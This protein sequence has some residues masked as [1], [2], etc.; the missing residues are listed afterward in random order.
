VA[1]AAK[2]VS[3]IFQGVDQSGA[4]LASVE[5]GMARVSA[6]TSKMGTTAGEATQIWQDAAGK[7]RNA[8]G[9]FASEAELAAAGV[10]KV[11]KAGDKLGILTDAMK[12]LATAAVAKAFIDANVALEKFNAVMVA[13][14]GSTEEAKR[15]F[16]FVR[17]LSDR[18]GVSTLDVADAFSKFAAAT[19]GT[20]LEGEDARTIFE[21]F[22][23]AIAKLGG[24]SNDVAG[25]MVQLAQGVSKGKFELDDLKSIA[26]RVP[27]FFTTFAQALGVSTEELFEMVSAGKITGDEILKLG[28]VFSEQFGGQRVGGY[29]AELERL[30]NAIGDVFLLVGETGA[31][32]IFGDAVRV[33]GQ[34]VVVLTAI[35]EAL[36]KSIGTFFAALST[37]DWSN[38]SSTI[39]GIW[40]SASEKIG[41]AW[42]QMQK[43]GEETGK[44]K[45]TSEGVGSALTTGLGGA[46][47]AAKELAEQTKTLDKDLKEL[48]LDPKKLREGTEQ[49]AGDIVKAFQ[50]IAKNPA[51]NGEEIVAAFLVSL[52]KLTDSDKLQ[53]TR[54][55]IQQAFES[56]KISSEQ[57]TAAIGAL[58]DKASG[59][60]DGMINGAQKTT[61]IADE[62]KKAAD[63][64]RRAE[65]A[66]RAYQ[67]RLQELASNERIKLIEAR[68]AINVAEV[69][70]ETK[71]IE[72]AFES[73]NTTVTSTGDV[74]GKAFGALG[75][76]ESRF[77]PRFELIERQLEKENKRRDD[78]LEL[79][80]KLTEEQIDALKAKTKALQ[81]GDALIKVDGAG[82][83]PH[84]EAFMWEIL[85]TIQTR[86]NQDGLEM[87]VGV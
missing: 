19:K 33:T 51:A 69:E 32:E 65:E 76:I 24:S 84:L 62:T 22:S 71:R 36:G 39:D 49:A 12:S 63:E 4:A 52:G 34:A 18:L 23:S 48:G 59:L 40:S 55:A 87:L 82:L 54:D 66:T 11:G 78:A 38:F 13:V 50:A 27:G 25:A 61:A 29:A 53:Q 47:D 16:E 31:F 20:A 75:G 70:A 7:W 85:R 79:Q 10:E 74:I 83:Q 15:E 68:V 21:G 41:K 17:E 86:V 9:Q 58:T 30:K 57:Y 64:A 2:T 5:A 6:A 73:I 26:E 14:T 46:T 8:A 72:A 77:D 35:L 56:G 45:T 44:V 60:W 37:G 42:D 43:L 28:G 1:D 81:N 3:I 67:L 80:K